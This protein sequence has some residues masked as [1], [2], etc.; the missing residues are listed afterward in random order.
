MYSLCNVCRIANLGLVHEFRLSSTGVIA[1]NS[2]SVLH[3]SEFGRVAGLNDC[4]ESRMKNSAKLFYVLLW[5][6]TTPGAAMIRFRS[7]DDY[8]LILSPGPPY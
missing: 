4:I 5:R 3:Q 2:G 8:P 7:R 6:H 1:E